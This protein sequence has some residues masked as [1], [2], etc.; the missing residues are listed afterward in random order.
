MT[1]L[2]TVFSW[3]FFSLSS[4]MFGTAFQWWIRNGCTR[5]SSWTHPPLCNAFEELQKRLTIVLGT[6]RGSTSQ[7]LLEKVQM[8]SAKY[9][10]TWLI[11][12][13]CTQI[14]LFHLYSLFILGKAADRY[15][16]TSGHHCQSSWGAHGMIRPSYWCAHAHTLKTETGGILRIC[17][18]RC[19]NVP[20][21]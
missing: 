14:S 7:N 12:Y 13:S 4:I 10:Y 3:V 9:H 5:N 6:F 11:F 16:L 8:F 18:L 2:I 21:H 15:P 19:L 1:S 20:I 17:Y